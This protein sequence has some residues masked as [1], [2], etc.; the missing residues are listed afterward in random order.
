[1]YSEYA[2]AAEE[3]ADILLLL[4]QLVDM[5][6]CVMDRRWPEARH[7]MKRWVEKC[8][9]ARPSPSILPAR[10]CEVF[11]PLCF[12]V[13]K[14]PDGHD[15]RAVKQRVKDQER[16]HPRR[17][18]RGSIRRLWRLGRVGRGRQLHRGRHGR[19]ALIDNR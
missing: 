9:S 11:M 12:A 1:M 3:A 6:L 17:K 14:H 2:G 16:L 19:S 10:A 7:P 15:W 5:L 13:A 18:L 8:L 4:E